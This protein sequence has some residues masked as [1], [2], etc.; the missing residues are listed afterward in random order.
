MA[1]PALATDRWEAPEAVEPPSLDRVRNAYR[2][3]N[4]VTGMRTAGWVTL[5]GGIVAL[6]VGVALGWTEFKVAGVAAVVV[7]LLCLLFTIGTP[8]FAVRLHLDEHS[9]V[10]G[11]PAGGVLQVLNQAQRRHLGSRLDLPVGDRAASFSVPGLRPGEVMSEPF[12]IPTD[13]RGVVVIGPAQSVQGDP[14]ALTGRET[15]W[16]GSME[17]FVHPRTVSLPGRQTGFV[18]DLEGHASAHISAA[19]MNFHALRPYAPGD[20]RRHVHWR[21]T[22]RAGELMVRQF[23]ESRM[24]RVVVAL[25]TGRSSW[26]D[27]DEFELGVSAAGSIAVA[28]LLG[29]SPLATLTSTETLVALTPTRA[30]DEL[31]TVELT[32]RG[33]IADLVHT[34]RRREP[35][36]SIAMVVTGS[37]SS[38]TALRRACS[39]FD[40]DTRV[41]GIRVDEGSGLRVR[42]AGNVTVLQVGSLEELPRALRRAME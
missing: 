30:L 11:T 6:V 36:A 8:N 16:T 34:T 24:S 40:V 19:D 37:S 17:L 22:A 14:F 33:G 31:C 9:V 3:L 28:T 10:V 41:I 27:D 1:A 13:R 4:R 21:S 2:A 20:D 38:M 5:F 35:G 7:V 29:E 39:L 15:R 25:D 23:E 42:T 32:A 26:L 12:H 18:H